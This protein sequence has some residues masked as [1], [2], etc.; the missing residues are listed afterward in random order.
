MVAYGRRQSPI[1]PHRRN[2]SRCV[3]T[4]PRAQA[5]AAS[6]SSSGGRRY[7]ASTPDSCSALSS[8][9]SPWQSQPGT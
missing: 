3:S 5:A 4:A 8:I 2:E 9:G 6:R 7:A 1:T